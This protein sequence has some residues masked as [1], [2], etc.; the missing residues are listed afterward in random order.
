M[1]ERER[2]GRKN[3]TEE[4]GFQPLIWSFNRFS[5]INDTKYITPKFF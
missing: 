3:T 5:K 4:N 1:K 2:V